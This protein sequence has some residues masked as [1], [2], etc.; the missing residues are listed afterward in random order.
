MILSILFT[1]ALEEV[2][3][4]K[5]ERQMIPAEKEKKRMS[6]EIKSF[7]SLLNSIFFFAFLLFDADKKLVS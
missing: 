2:G 5:Q 7:D 6:L 1:R 4:P 3:S